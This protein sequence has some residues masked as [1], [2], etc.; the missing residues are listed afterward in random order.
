MRHAYAY[1]AVLGLAPDAD[2]R[3]LGAAVTAEL[4]GHWEHDPPCPRA[5][6]HTAA[7]RDGEDVRLR[8][9]FANEPEC[10]AEVRQRI[11]RALTACD[12]RSGAPGSVRPEEQAHAGRLVGSPS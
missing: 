5:P 9:L 3:A 7:Q 6:H 11:G 8:I 10:A 12:V 2:I 1:D 4:C